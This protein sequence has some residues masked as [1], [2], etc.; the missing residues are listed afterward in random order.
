METDCPGELYAV[1]FNR[2][3]KLI[4][5]KR[6]YKVYLANDADCEFVRIVRETTR[7]S[8]VAVDS[9]MSAAK[10]AEKFGIEVPSGIVSFY[11]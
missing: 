1:G 3:M 5:A 10:I 4:K 9:S 6:V 8:D 11:V 2:F 7:S